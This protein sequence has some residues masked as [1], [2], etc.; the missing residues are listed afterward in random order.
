MIE[1]TSQNVNNLNDRFQSI[2]TDISG[3]QTVETQLYD[4]LDDN[5]LSYDQ[6]QQVINKINE[7]SQMRLNMYA[8]MKQMYSFYQQDAAASQT[9]LGQEITALDIIEN[10]LNEAKKRMNLIEDQKSNKLRLVEINTYY[11][12]RYNAHSK[13]MKIVIIM[14]IPLIILAILAN[15]GILPSK[16]HIVLSGLII[17]IGV[18]LIGSQLLDL[19]NRDNMNWDEY[20][21]PF[22]RES[23]PTDTGSGTATDPWKTPSITCVGEECCIN[24]GLVY[25]SSLNI[26]VLN[27]P[28][29]MS[30]S[31]TSTSTTGTT[32]TSTE[33]FKTLEKG[34]YAQ[35][36]ATPIT[37][38]V[39]PSYA[40]LSKF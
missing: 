5:K 17:V 22:N 33:G 8:S 40:S 13:L 28:N 14:C 23:V 16:L 18:I 37:N 20:N 34:A 6:K 26:C 9:T 7:I 10:E 3:L 36:K 2:L 25:D 12:K 39:M 29:T 30:T 4:S 32:S 21:W 27:T 15:K 38:S 31:T 19:S 11:G 1:T 24:N 35:V